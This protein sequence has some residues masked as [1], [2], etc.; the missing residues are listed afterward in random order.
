MVNLNF[1]NKKSLSGKNINK[2]EL[3][4]MYLKEFRSIRDIAEILGCS[5]DRIYRALK[6]YGI[7]RRKSVEKRSQLQDYDLSYLKRE[8][9][10]KGFNKVAQE[11]GVHVTTLR[12]FLKKMT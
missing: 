10:Q 7:E 5:K 4:T 11:I 2:K 12:R 8:I 6:E 9:R 3:I 1:E